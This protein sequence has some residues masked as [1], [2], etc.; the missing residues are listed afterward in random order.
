MYLGEDRAVIKE[1]DLFLTWL[2]EAVAH[3][4]PEP[5]AVQTPPRSAQA[6]C[7]SRPSRYEATRSSVSPGSTR[8]QAS[9]QPAATRNP[10]TPVGNAVFEI[11]SGARTQRHA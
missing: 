4:V 6:R 8:P 9:P 10:T 7:A 1:V 11:R 5:R 3:G 2:E